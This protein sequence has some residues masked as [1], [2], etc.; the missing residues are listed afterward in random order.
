ML[1]SSCL[2]HLHLRSVSPSTPPPSLLL[3]LSREGDG[4]CD[5][6]AERRF[7]TLS[8]QSPEHESFIRRSGDWV[9]G[10]EAGLS[11]GIGEG[12]NREVRF[13]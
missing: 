5:P 12:G 8:F 13:L 10:E 3:A 2:P 6:G 4:L 7:P 1:P 9:G 11:R